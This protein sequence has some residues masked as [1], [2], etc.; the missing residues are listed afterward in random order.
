MPGPQSIRA[1]A[2]YTGLNLFTW[3][4]YGGLPL[5]STGRRFT[6]QPAAAA[7]PAFCFYAALRLTIF[8]SKEAICR[9]S[10]LKI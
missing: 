5:S 4:I 10:F 3:R 1:A 7:A 6:F 8:P 9:A 2:Q